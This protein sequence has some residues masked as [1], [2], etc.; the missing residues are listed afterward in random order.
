MATGDTRLEVFDQHRPLL[1]GVAYRMLGSWA[2]AE[3]MLQEA[4]LRWQRAPDLEIQSPRAFLV[5]I[6]T[7]L[8]INYLQSAPVKRE[9]YFGQWLP[10]P[11]V[12]SPDQDPFRSFQID[13]S[14]SLAF[15]TLLERISPVERAVLLLREVFD[16]EYAEISRILDQSEANCRQILRR[17]RQHIQGSERR[18]DASSKEREELLRKFVEASS[19]GSL[20]GLVALLSREAAF[21]SDGGGKAPALPRPIYGPENIARGILE[22]LR[23][24]VPKNLLRRGV[25]INGRPGVVTFLE[26]RPFS[27]LTIDVAGGRIRNIYVITN[28][29]KLKRVPPLTSLPA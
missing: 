6:V 14:L 12:T 18:F 11:I 28:P 2:D 13:E 16:Y 3:D 15:L 24:Y 5:T 25:E 4:F 23:K 21:Y 29:E 17:A 10:E 19:Q 7:R 22:G 9:E 8:C 27:A 1:Q 26:G 20:E